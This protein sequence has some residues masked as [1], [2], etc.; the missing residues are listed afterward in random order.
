MSKQVLRLRPQLI[1]VRSSITINASKEIVWDEVV[2]SSLPPPDEFIFKT[3]IAYPIRAEIDG[4]GVGAVRYCV[5]STGR[6]VE[7][8]EVWDEPNFLQ[9]SVTHSPPPMKELSIYSQIHPPHL[10]GFL[11]SRKGQFKLIEIGKNKTLVQGTTW[12]ENKMW[13][14]T[15]WKFWSD[16]IIHKIHMRVL[17]HIK[18]SSEQNFRQAT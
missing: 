14:E 18:Y 17:S 1:E 7:P 4:E 11:K 3:G 5:F 13:P 8:I 6:F 12:Y 16:Y 2:S 15:Y 10:E 9:F